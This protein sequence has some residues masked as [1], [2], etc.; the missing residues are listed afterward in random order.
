MSKKA[1]FRRPG[2]TGSL[3]R[4]KNADYAGP[5]KR[6]S[7]VSVPEDLGLTKR[8]SI[9]LILVLC[10]FYFV[11]TGIIAKMLGIGAAALFLF[12]FG[13]LTVAIL[14]MLG[15]SYRQYSPQSWTQKET[16]WEEQSESALKRKLRHQVDLSVS[17]SSTDSIL[18]DH[19]VPMQPNLES[20]AF[21]PYEKTLSKEHDYQARHV[22]TRQQ[23]A[24]AALYQTA[25]AQLKQCDLDAA[26]LSFK[27]LLHT[28]VASQAYEKI[29]CIQMRQR[30]FTEAMIAFEHAIAHDP[31]S[32]LAYEGIGQVYSSTGNLQQAITAFQKA[33]KL[34]PKSENAH[35][36]LGRVFLKQ[37]QP[38]EAV[39]SFQEA[40]TLRSS[41]ASA[42]EGLGQAYLQQSRLDDATT[43]FQ[44]AIKLR[45]Q[46]LL[47]YNGLGQALL[48]QGQLEDVID[49]MQRALAINPNYRP[50]HN[51]LNKTI[52]QKRQL[53][54]TADR[55]E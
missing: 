25:L 29:G 41:F 30:R 19:I 43:A 37:E 21:L 24:T 45:P 33:T 54:E 23:Q 5:L 38:K 8:Q 3:V 39:E 44:Q 14:I 20:D 7:S 48:R 10:I 34:S 9:V 26:L 16:Q 27:A 52:A 2:R 18:M 4:S 35:E 51:L 32:G 15:V 1:K 36:S 28:D 55:D 42:Y 53:P 13:V 6:G 47:A 11:A 12:A 46:F 17:H 31:Q 22:R 40:I 49:C 50:A